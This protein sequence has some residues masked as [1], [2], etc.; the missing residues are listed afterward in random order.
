[1]KIS[2][3][4]YHVEKGDTL[5]SIAEKIGISPDALKRYHN[6]YCNL[7]ELI[8]HDLKNVHKIFIPPPDRLA[9][10][11]ESKKIVSRNNVLP[12]PYLFKDFYTENYEVNEHFERTDT[13]DLT[14]NYLIS[15]N[16][17]E[18]ADK[19]FIVETK[20]SGYKKNSDTPDDKI[21]KLSLACMNALY[22]IAFIVPAQGSIQGFYDH[23]GMIAK[24]ENKRKDLEEFFV[25]E[26]SQAYFNKFRSY[27]NNEDFL[28][29]R[30]RSTILYQAL[31][32]KMDWFHKNK[33]WE[34]ELYIVQNSFP[35]KF[36]LEAKYNHEITDYVETM[37]YGNINDSYSLQELLKGRK[38][39]ELA[40]EPV[41]A[42][43]IYKYTTDKNTRQ[44]LKIEVNIILKNNNDIYSSYKL[45]LIAKKKE[46]TVKKFSTLADQ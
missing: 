26:V 37:V 17:R 2:I 24:F 41:A 10:L 46:K 18:T 31:F 11:K 6:T 12:S 15:V 29:E 42:E 20:N 45:V 43:I 38:I 44:L 9:E 5:Q 22:P 3:S 34:E 23:K 21:S 35:V 14:I 7:D 27:L 36:L 39:S 33:P 32:P 40:E 30:F 16:F 4:T 8:G 13:E 1:M 25:G 28:F 19:G